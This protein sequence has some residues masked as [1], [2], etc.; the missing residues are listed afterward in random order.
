M[1][2][3]FPFHHLTR[4]ALTACVALS[5]AACG[6]TETPAP[7]SDM[8][9]VQMALTAV[10]SDGDTYRLRSATIQ[11]TGPTTASVALDEAYGDSPVFAATV[12]VGEYTITLEEGWT[13]QRDSGQGF[14]DVDAEMVSPNPAPVDVHRDTTSVVAIVFQ[15]PD[16][17][18]EFAT[19]DLEVWLGVN[20]LDCAH[21]EYVTRSC[22]ANLTGRQ[23]RTCSQGW[24]QDWS[25]CSARCDRGYCL[26]KDPATYAS[27]TI[28]KTVETIGFESYATGSEVPDDLF[29]ATHGDIFSNNVSF[30]SV[31]ASNQMFPA[32][33]DTPFIGQKHAHVVTYG[34]DEGGDASIRS[35]AGGKNYSGFDALEAIF[36]DD[37]DVYGATFTVDQNDNGYTIE[38]HNADCEIVAEIP[39]SAGDGR[40]FI[41]LGDAKRHATEPASSFIIT[42]TRDQSFYGTSAWSLTEFSYAISSETGD[43]H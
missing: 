3:N 23:F 2:K 15:T 24:W 10:G 40:H 14:A 11:I 4:V 42:P 38:V 34:G 21:G 19:G 26:F 33:S 12:D 39:V 43:A 17:E 7:T 18:I 20:H 22:G 13:L 37:M 36:T 1:F 25:E 32:E 29:A 16:A 27:A 30:I 28:N 35:S 5:A 6:E 8:G 41:V 31:G 9:T